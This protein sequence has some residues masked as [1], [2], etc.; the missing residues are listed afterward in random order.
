MLY[1]LDFTAKEAVRAQA[2]RTRD[3]HDEGLWGDVD[4]LFSIQLVG[5]SDGESTIC[6][7]W[8]EAVED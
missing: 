5:E 2:K 1:A 4:L 7:S 6:D 8:D 3:A